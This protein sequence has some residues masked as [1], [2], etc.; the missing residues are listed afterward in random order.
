MT[1]DTVAPDSA[2]TF[3]DIRSL[4]SSSALARDYAHDFSRL[5]AFYAG[6]PADRQAWTP[7]I[8]AVLAH[9]SLSAEGDAHSRYAFRSRFPQ[10]ETTTL[11]VL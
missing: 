9:P 3:L 4:P 7:V 6:N 5:A 1:T 8:D 10:C 11:S 2:R